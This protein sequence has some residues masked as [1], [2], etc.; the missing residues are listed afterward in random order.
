[1]NSYLALPCVFS[2]YSEVLCVPLFFREMEAP[3]CNLVRELGLE[4]FF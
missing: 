4:P 2:T 1:M 3:V